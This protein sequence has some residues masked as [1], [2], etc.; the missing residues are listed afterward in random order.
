MNA[1][2]PDARDDHEI[3]GLGC[4]DCP[5]VLQ[6]RVEGHR[7]H[8]HFECR[9]GHSFSLEE[10]LAAKEA[11]IEEALWG[12]VVTLEEMA[13]LIGDLDRQGFLGR[14]GVAAGS[15]DRGRLAL[16]HSEQ[17]RNMIQHDRPIN[18]SV[19]IP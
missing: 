1:L 17:I 12:A 6:V 2:P 15:S 7:R 19:E 5:G 18:L 4:P 10:L 16:A 14:S 3:T 8:L 13:S 11:Q 9:I